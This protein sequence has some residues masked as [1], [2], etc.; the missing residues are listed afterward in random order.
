MPPTIFDSTAAANVGNTLDLAMK[1]FGQSLPNWL[2]STEDGVSVY[3][4]AGG[5]TAAGATGVPTANTLFAC[6]FW[7]GPTGTVSE[8]AFFVNTIG[9]GGS[10][11]RCGIYASNPVGPFYPTKLVVDGGQ[12]ATDS[13]TGLKTTA[14]LSV[15]LD[16]HAMY[17]MAFLT[18]ATPPTLNMINGVFGNIFGYAGATL[19]F[20]YGW[21]VAQTYG[22]L[23]PQYPAGGTILSGA[24]TMPVLFRRYS[25][26][27]RIV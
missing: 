22:A 13:G 18:N 21:T 7:S 1:L 16:P 19:A 23:P 25:S 4:M 3:Y 15:V 12:V 5:H 11:S 6:P 2:L 14:G 17:Y 8:V 20:Q 27:S 10:L 26:V 24:N 9:A